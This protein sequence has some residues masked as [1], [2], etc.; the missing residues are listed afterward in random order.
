MLLVE[1]LTLE[2]P[3]SLTQKGKGI[4]VA[5]TTRMKLLV[6]LFYVYIYIYMSNGL[7]GISQ[8]LLL[9]SDRTDS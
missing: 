2:S 6:H 4:V 1:T 7:L 5:T 9:E 3:T 8:V